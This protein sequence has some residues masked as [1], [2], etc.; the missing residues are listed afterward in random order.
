MEN[1][2]DYMPHREPFLFVDRVVKVTDSCIK[3][4]KQI[5][6][7]ESFFAGLT[8]ALILR[9]VGSWCWPQFSIAIDIFE[10]REVPNAQG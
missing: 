10:P 5:Q 6:A 1:F 7:N 3:T 8:Q 2:L 9:T 4:E